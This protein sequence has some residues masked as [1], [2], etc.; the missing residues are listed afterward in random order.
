M[1]SACAALGAALLLGAAAG[2]DAT[3]L[4]SEV[5]YD[6]IG[7]DD[8]QSFIE[9]YGAP[10]TSLAGLTIEAING[11]GG[12]VTHSLALTGT[13][14]A[15]GV[16][17]IADGVAGGGTSVAN[18]N[19]I[20]DFDFQ[21]GPDSVVLRDATSILDAVGYGVFAAGDVFAGEGSPTVDPTAGNAIARRFANVDT[22]DNAADWLGGAPT[23]GVVT[24]APVP[25]ASALALL[26]PAGAAFAALRAAGLRRR[27]RGLAQA[28]GTAA[29]ATVRLRSLRSLRAALRAACLRRRM[30]GLA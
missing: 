18:A 10:G 12:T 15:G 28:S 26:A 25:E 24:L 19:L 29:E 14:G 16:F 17:V 4:L 1:R 11:T 13:I 8:G 27:M 5:F 21:N 30:R 7:S 9:I 22:G 20:L 3:P 23:P 6:A 2:A